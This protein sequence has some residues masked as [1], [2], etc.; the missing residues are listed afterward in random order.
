MI[1]TSLAPRARLAALEKQVK[2]LRKEWAGLRKQPLSDHGQTPAVVSG[3]RHPTASIPRTPSATCRSPA[4]L[5]ALALF[6]MACS[7]RLD[8]AGWNVRV[9]HDET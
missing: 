2:A 1:P 8:R 5:F 6:A 3:S 9:A 4:I 7:Q